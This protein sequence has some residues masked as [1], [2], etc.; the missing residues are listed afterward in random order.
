MSGENAPAAAPAETQAP[1]SELQPGASAPVDGGAA[2]VEGQA[3]TDAQQAEEAAALAAAAERKRE[4]KNLRFG[5]LTKE[6]NKAREEAAYWRGVA[7]AARTGKPQAQEPA[8]QPEAPK[9]PPDPKSYPQ[10][11]FD[12]RYIADLAKHEL[13]EEMRAEDDRRAQAERSRAANEAL[14]SGAQRLQE[15]VDAAYAEADGANGQFFQNAPRFMEAAARSLPVPI[16]DLIT[17]STNRIHVAEILGRGGLADEPVDF[18]TLAKM[19]PVQ[20]ARYIAKIDDRVTAL[21][22]SQSA[23]PAPAARPAP[24]PSPQP[25]P[26]VSP[27]GAAP[28]FN[29]EK[30]SF[31]EIE[32][33]FAQL[34]GNGA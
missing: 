32:A 15:T 11:E 31:A 9:G 13:R 17:E 33:R 19:K 28:Q 3:P 4:E 8:P 21:L 34:R 23:Q 18:Q 30:A 20:A 29:P 1:A 24:Q 22:K 26:T 5:D 2:P 7:E 10:G 16:V 14:Q 12:S 25:I 27:S 6:R